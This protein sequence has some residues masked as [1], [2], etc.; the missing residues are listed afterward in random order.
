MKFFVDYG[1]GYAFN[2]YESAE[3]F[4]A[5]RGIHPEDIYEMTAEE[6][7]EWEE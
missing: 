3:L 6:A 2:T 4:C 7:A 5:E 1:F